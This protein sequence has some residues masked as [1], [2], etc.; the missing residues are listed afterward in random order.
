[1]DIECNLMVSSNEIVDNFSPDFP[2]YFICGFHDV[3]VQEK[4]KKLV[5][6]K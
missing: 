4:K 2:N 6:E 5:M 3:G 1:M